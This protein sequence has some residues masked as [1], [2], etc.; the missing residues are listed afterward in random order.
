MSDLA[1]LSATCVRLGWS[2]S[3]VF[4]AAVLAV[5][6]LRRPCRQW[7]GPRRACALWLLPPLAML[8]SASPHAEGSMSLWPSVVVN[9]VA[10]PN[11]PLP[12]STGA[13]LVDWRSWVLL[14]WL[15]GFVAALL[16]AVRSQWRYRVRLRG[17]VHQETCFSRWPVMRA[18]DA[19]TGPALVGAWRP[20]IVV[21]ADFDARY[22][23]AERTLILAHEAM[24]ARRCDGVWS[25]LARLV[26]S[27]FWFHPLGW[28]A[29]SALRHDMELACDAAVMHEHPGQRR[30]YATAML[31]TVPRQTPL[32]VGCA[33]S[34]RHPLT[35]RIAM[36]KLGS[37]D[38]V[39]RASGAVVLGAV[40]L[41]GVGAA[42]AATA[43]AARHR[44]ATDRYALKVVVA[45]NGETPRLRAT[46][47]V[48]PGESYTFTTSLDKTLPPW[49][50]RF[51]VDAAAGGLLEVSGAMRGGTL[52]KPV[53]PRVRTYPGQEATIML[54][55]KPASG[56][57][58]HTIRVDLTPSIGC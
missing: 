30:R 9:L 36:L 47:C 42:Y 20:C 46:V 19:H 32:P 51:A 10:L 49:H 53:S 21:P 34:P 57:P 52:T 31:K 11:S 45:L 33:W 55:R 16:V 28:W 7:L 5:A 25:L 29:A 26:A 48:K 50:G 22:D 8:A 3:L 54:G 15:A 44:S 18:A 37:P 39:R 58:G 12:A 27:A 17:S 38:L 56:S 35:E 6:A 14:V 23:V 41:L 40:I 4:T 1:T 13:P 2:C 24:H 43:P